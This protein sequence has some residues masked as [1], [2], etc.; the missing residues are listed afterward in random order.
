LTPLVLDEKF[1][2]MAALFLGSKSQEQAGPSHK[3]HVTIHIE[4]FRFYQLTIRGSIR[5]F[6]LSPVARYSNSLSEVVEQLQNEK[7]QLERNNQQIQTDEQQ[8]QCNFQ[9]LQRDHG[10][11]KGQFHALNFL[12]L[13]KTVIILM[14]ARQVP[15]MGKACPRVGS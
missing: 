14:P 11:V 12:F 7:G 13:C 4:S 8:L 3:E 6:T 15:K 1:Q 5:K 9:L 2:E 10:D